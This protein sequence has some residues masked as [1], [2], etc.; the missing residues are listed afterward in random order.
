MSHRLSRHAL[1]LCWAGSALAGAGAWAQAMP[2][3]PAP[4]TGAYV[5]RVLDDSPQATQIDEIATRDTGWPRGWSVEAQSTRQSGMVSQNTQSLLFSGFLDTPDYGAFS[6]NFNLNR[7]LAPVSGLGLIGSTG[8]PTTVVPDGTRSGSTWR[9]DQRGMPFNGGWF[10]NNSVG[11]VNMAST[12]LARGIGRVYLPSL[13]IEGVAATLEQPGRTSFN[14]SAGRLGYFDGLHSQ[15]FTKGRGT[16]AGMGAQTQLAGAEGAHAANRVD[17]AVQAIDTRDF[18]PN[19]VPGYAQNT[20]SVWTAVAWQGLAPWADSLG[21]GFG[22]LADKVGGMRIQANLARSEG[23]PSAPGSLAPRDSATGVW[24]DATW[25][26]EMLKQAASVFYFEPSLRW[27]SDTL[28]NDLRGASWRGDLSTRQWQLGSHIEFSDSTSGLQGSSVFGN[29]FG[30]WRFDSRD[31]VAATLAA[32]SGRFAARSAQINWEHKSDWGDTQWRTDLAHGT[33]LRVLRTGV[34]HAWAVGETQSLSTSLA[35]EQSREQD[36]DRRTVLWG[37]LG[38]TPLP[39]GARLD[40][41]VRGS[42]GTGDNSARFL[43]ANARLSW[44][45][46]LGWSFI[47]QYT[48]ARGQESLNPAVVSSL[49]AATQPPLL[50]TPSNRSFMVALRYESRGGMASAPIGGLPGTGAGRLEGHVFF[51]QD[52]NGRREASEG[53]VPNVTVVLDRRYVART[54]AQGFYSFPLVAAGGHEIELIQDNLPLPWTSAGAPSRRVEVYV[55][56][57]ARADFPVQK[58]R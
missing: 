5:D 32:R 37:V 55:R 38:T 17:A 57:T 30:R 35:V 50:V 21:G 49:T 8:M 26:S 31:A 4:G 13:P 11:N 58:E 56:D 3:A 42:N 23:R 40:L 7:D 47:A 53:D 36:I 27:G 39:A 14:A 19:G 16:A 51:D 10:G 46:G 41:S 54:D 22:G 9:I 34:D 24:V 1:G 12:P 45:L 33:G 48:T 28:P 18:N 43:S 52:H 6:A 2:Q 44:P 20:R 25:R 29:L 15:G